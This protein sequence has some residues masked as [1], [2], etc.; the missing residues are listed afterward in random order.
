MSRPA[1][2]TRSCAPTTGGSSAPRPRASRSGTAAGPGAAACTR[3]ERSPATARSATASRRAS[4]WPS[5]SGSTPTRAWRAAGSRIWAA[6]LGRPG[7]RLPERRRVQ[8]RL[9]PGELERLRLHF[10]GLP[11]REGRFFVDVVVGTED[12]DA[13]LAFAERA[14]EL[15]VFSSDTSGAAES[16]RAATLSRLGIKTPASTAL[17]WRACP[18]RFSC[19]PAGVSRS[20]ERRSG[21]CAR[22]AVRCPSTA[23]SASATG[24]SRSAA[25][26]SSAR[27]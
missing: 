12:G 24:S 1:R 15:S 7:S 8:V 2:R 13:E 21:S 25:G 27:R 16:A 17:G 14:L 6:R 3:C 11:L 4:R 10:P 19:E 22:R 5:R 23:R 9:R 20:S 26:P 18:I